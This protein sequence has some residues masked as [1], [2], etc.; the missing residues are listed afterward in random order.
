MFS[1]VKI[2]LSSLNCETLELQKEASKF[3]L[4]MRK[5]L[6]EVFFN[7]ADMSAQRSTQVIFLTAHLT[8]NLISKKSP[9]SK[10]ICGV[11]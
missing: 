4:D 6:N 1:F 5:E 7:K 10:T 2:L 9:T 8:E 11:P 3:F